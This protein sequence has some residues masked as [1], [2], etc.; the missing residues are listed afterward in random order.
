[1][2]G[3][4]RGCIERRQWHCALHWMG[5]GGGGLAGKSCW[6]FLLASFIIMVQCELGV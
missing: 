3:G 5:G 1:V 2:P 6:D 4:V